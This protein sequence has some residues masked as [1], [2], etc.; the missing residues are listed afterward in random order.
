VGLNV[1]GTV[2][3]EFD[4]IPSTT[5]P[6]ASIIPQPGNSGIVQ[7]TVGTGGTNATDLDRD[8]Q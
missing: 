5:D 1:Y 3:A 6:T 4:I 8:K 7:A 2:A